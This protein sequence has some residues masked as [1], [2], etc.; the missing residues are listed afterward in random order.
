MRKEL[1]QKK[2]KITK[3]ESERRYEAWSTRNR[4]VPYLDRNIA[5]YYDRI[6]Y[7]RP[8]MTMSIN[9]HIFL[10]ELD[11]IS[12]YTSYARLVEMKK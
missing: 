4:C 7:I 11:A 8:F 9:K 2:G 6:D 10:G 1:F 12:L 5:V 3:K